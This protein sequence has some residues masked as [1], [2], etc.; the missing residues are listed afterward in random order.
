VH[1]KPRDPLI[2]QRTTRQPGWKKTVAVGLTL[3]ILQLAVIQ[4]GWAQQQDEDTTQSTASQFG[5][6]VSSFFLTIPYGLAKVVY[7]MLGG[8]MG[9][10]T[11][12]LTGGNDRAAKAVWDSSLR[13]TYVITPDHLKGDKAVR[14]L[15]V[16]GE[17]DGAAAAETVPAM[18]GP[19]KK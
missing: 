5:L 15:G 10:F 19:A 13:G 16:P 3:T 8:I 18:P 7:A 9:G 2:E 11:Y 4:P 6:G 1:T 12:A 17:S 14:F